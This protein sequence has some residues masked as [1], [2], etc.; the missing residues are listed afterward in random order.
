MSPPIIS[1]QTLLDEL[2]KVAPEWNIELS[3]SDYV[4]NPEKYKAVT[5]IVTNKKNPKLIGSF[6][7]I[8]YRKQTWQYGSIY[9]V[10]AQAIYPNDEDGN[11]LKLAAKFSGHMGKYWEINY[12][13]CCFKPDVK[14][15]ND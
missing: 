14:E 7:Y 9:G 6:T 11:H 2:S 4:E 5:A 15:T 3:P 1:Q 8:G 13:P 12:G 10:I